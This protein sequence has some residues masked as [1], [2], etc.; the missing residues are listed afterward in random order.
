MSSLDIGVDLGTSSII[1]GTPGRGILL[2][3]PSVVAVDSHSGEVI[4]I[5]QKAYD[6]IGRTP[7]SIKTI[8]PV[9]DGV[10]SNFS[11]T[12]AIMRYTMQ[13]VSR[14]H[15]IKPRVIVCIPSQITGVESQSVID[16]TVSAGARQVYLIEEPIAAAIG[17]GLNISKP[18]GHLIVDIGGGTTD[19]AVLSLNGVV[20]KRSLR[21]AGRTFDEA[22][23]RHM[24]NK[25]NLLVGE[26]TAEQV[27]IEIGSV[28]HQ[29]E[30]RQISVKGRGLVNGLPT[31]INITTSELYEELTEIALQIAQTV[32][33][34]LERT[35]P[36][37]VGDI[38]Q[39]GLVMTG[40]GSL[41]C[42]LNRL[43][44]DRLGVEA[45]IAGDAIQS[46]ALGTIQAFSQLEG[47]FDG[48][49]RPSTHRH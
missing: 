6:M 49:T 41:L 20:C 30:N 43:L 46:V 3:E 35:P 28:H 31:K 24:R 16:A 32:Q 10:V 44:E 42:G 21:V 37:L 40:G 36:E 15:L 47:L 1:A 14:N 11:M 48:F 5:G 7:A 9:E 18:K 29:Y 34:V 13:S 12:E 4:V 22:I 27:K 19:V 8:L 45:N 23:I 38:K 17:A 2:R 33:N 25:H 26:K 39:A